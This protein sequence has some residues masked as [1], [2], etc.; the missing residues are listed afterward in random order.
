VA[1]YHLACERSLWFEGEE[2][3]F[4]PGDALRVFFSYRYTP[5]LARALLARH[6]LLVQAEWT[7]ASGEEGLFVCQRAPA[8]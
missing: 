4:R 7:A 3:R 5:S 8:G 2:F 1:H 6:G